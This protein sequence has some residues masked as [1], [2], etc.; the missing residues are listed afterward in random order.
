VEVDKMRQYVILALGLAVCLTGA[1]LMAFGEGVL[2]EEH[3]GISTVIG[4]VGIG[5]LGTFAATFAA[6]SSKRSS[7]ETYHQS[8]GVL[9]G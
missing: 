8:G 5:I 4:I 3:A 7:K 2:G 6:I 1:A 9:N